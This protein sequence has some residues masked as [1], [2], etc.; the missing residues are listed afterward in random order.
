MVRG[1]KFLLGQVV[2]PLCFL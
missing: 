2:Q 1:K